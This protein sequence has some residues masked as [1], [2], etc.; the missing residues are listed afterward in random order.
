[1]D[2]SSQRKILRVSPACEIPLL[3]GEITSALV[4]DGPT[5][6]FGQLTSILAPAHAAVVIGT[7]GSS[8]VAKEVAISG[9]SLIASAKASNKFLDARSGDRWSLLLP[10]TH[11]A[12]V[13]VI[14]R[15]MEV[16]TLP[17]DLR[18]IE[19]PY[20][21]VNFT[22]IVPTQLFRALNG[23]VHLLNHLQSADKVLVGGAGISQGMHNQALAAGINVVT[24][25]GMTE[26][27]GG[28]V[29]NGQPLEGVEVDVT[30]GRIRIRGSVLAF[31][32][33]NSDWNLEDN[34]FVTNDLG[35]MVNDKLVV[36]G[37]SDDVIISG[38][39]NISLNTIENLIASRYPELEC[40]AFAIK[41][42]RWG[43]TLHIAF[44]G[45][46]DELEITQLLEKEIGFFAKPK[47]FH[48]VAALPL[49]GI[50]KVD[51][52]SLAKGVAHE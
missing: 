21:R 13:N 20:P 12:A 43:Q 27:S 16:G 42:P 7:S 1:M 29:Y 10:L 4:G 6:G 5:L 31:G 26:T 47:G 2:N 24:T 28:C 37:R 8:G 38:G 41:D 33:L 45:Q 44:V 34:W 40:A 48:P 15:S 51:R 46:C 18:N 11:V 22:S 14:I 23:D 49:L 50:G 30:R 39:E 3:A 32:Y 19:G 35:E 36:L 52:Q 9:R 17:I 25:Y